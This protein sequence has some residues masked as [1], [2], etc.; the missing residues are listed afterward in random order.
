MINAKILTDNDYELLNA[1]I[2]GVD[3][4]MENHGCLTLEMN[5]HGDGWGVCFGG[6]VLGHGYLG[7]NED[8][9]EGSAKGMESLLRIM[10]VIGV[11]RFKD[12]KD[13]YV[14]VARKDNYS[15]KI[16][17]NIIKDKWFD[18]EDFFNGGE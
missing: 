18:V 7:A 1:R 14:R 4:S 6:Y 11:E 8:E 15:I 17:G 2:A 9:F 13:K 12:L 16:I 3:L 5:L 10:D